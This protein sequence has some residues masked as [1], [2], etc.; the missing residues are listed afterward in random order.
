[1]NLIA[2]ADENWGIGYEGKLL[3][4]VPE[5]I[6]QFKDKTT[7]KTVVMGRITLESLPK[8]KPLPNRVNIILSDNPDFYIEGCLIVHTL[9]ELF[10]ELTHYVDDD[11]FIIGGASIYHLLLPY[12]RRAYITR[13]HK[14]FS[15]DRHLPNLDTLPN[16]QKAD[17]SLDQWFEG[18]RYNY[19][20]YENREPL[21]FNNTNTK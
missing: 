12:C 11:V 1:M 19:C 8:S 7:G 10:G 15:A 4:R 9:N 16:W 6:R 3:C 18:M 17:S 13:F 21:H 5:D 20:L 14:N 2:S